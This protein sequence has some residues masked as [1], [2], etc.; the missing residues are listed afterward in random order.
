MVTFFFNQVIVLWT[1]NTERFC[2]IKTGLNDT[3]ANLLESIKRNEKEISPS[4]LFAVASILEGVT[5]I[6]GSPQNTFVPGCLELAE[7]RKVSIV[8]GVRSVHIGN[9]T[10]FTYKSG[11]QFITLCRS[12]V[13]EYGFISKKLN[14]SNINFS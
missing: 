3:A 4:T 9:I 2:D 8:L 10:V 11:S 1:A 5:Y 7:K 12:C 14:T 6:N 13:L